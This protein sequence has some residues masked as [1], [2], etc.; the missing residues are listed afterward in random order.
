MNAAGFPIL[1]LLTWLPLVGGLFIMTVRGDEQT[2]ASNARW[3]ALWTSLI[4]FILSLLLWVRFDQSVPGFQFQE[5]QP[6]L[7]DYGVA[8][9]MGVDGISVLFVLLS[10]ALTPICILASWDSV[11]SRVREYMLA[12][13]VLETMMVGMFSAQDFVL[14]YVFFEGVLIPMFLIIGVW[15]GPRRVYASMKFFL[16]TLAGSVLLLLAL[17]AAW[18]QAGTTD[19]SVLMTT[20]FPARMQFWLF[21]AFFASFAV[22][23]PM[24]PL[25]TWLPDAHVEAPT[26]GSVILAGVLLKMGAYGFLRFSLPLLPDA[27]AHAAPWMYALG[28]VAVIY[29]SL[30]AL[31]QTD[32]K[33]LIAY[34][35][36]AHMGVVII[37]IFTFN[38]QGIEG[39]LVQMLSHGIVS[40]ALFLCVGVVYDRIHTRDIDRYGGLAERMPGYSLVFLFF[41]MASMGLPGT[42]GF[43]GEFLVLVGAFKVSLYLALLGSLGMILG[44]CYMLYLYRRIIFGTLTKLDLKGILDLSP[45]ETGR[46]R[47]AD[48]ADVLDGHLS[49]H[50]HRLLRRDRE[51]DGRASPGGTRRDPAGRDP[52]MNW[53]LALPEIVLA[54][55]AMAILIIGVLQKRDASLLCTML[56]IGALLIT[57]GL[58]LGNAYGSGYRGL[59]VSDG[60]GVF[61]K[62]LIL[63]G[64]G[65]SAILALDYNLREGIARFE[66]PVLIL[67]STVGM[68]IMSSTSSLMTL[69]LGL[70]LQSLALYVLCA[71][72][73]DDVRSAE[74]GLKFFILGALASGLLL[75]GIS[76]AYGFAGSMQFADLARTLTDPNASTT[77][78]VVGIVFIVAGLAFKLSAVPFH[79]WTPDV[80]EGAPTPVTAF[81]STAPKVA[82]I[83]LLLRVLEVPF[84]HLGHQWTQLIVLISI[85][86]MLL[87]SFAAIGQKNIK[88]LMAYSSIGHMGYALIGLAVGTAEGIQ[89]VLVY[90]VTYVFMSIGVFAILAAMRRRGRAL[91]QISDLAGLGRTDGLMAMIMAIL[92]FSMAGIP[93]F[94]G[95]LGKLYVFLPAIRSGYY[96]LAVI[97]VLTSVVGA[98]Y[99]LRVIKVMYFDDAAAPMDARPA[100][101]LFVAAVGGLATTFI[102]IFAAPIVSAAGV[103]ARVLFG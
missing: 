63:S 31:A 44:A 4:V 21:L 71:F 47:A 103:A 86:S 14:F 16:Y 32:M 22:K 95:F 93:P 18:F 56:A 39:A 82:A 27:S 3:A 42:S 51:R 12:F 101:N 85:A 20:D 10:T 37:G 46:V 58:V 61:L 59:F 1:S 24:W 69:Y 75:Y 9:R 87:G 40:A 17:L 80:Y 2:V 8:Y 96:T 5:S 26:A 34:S 60:F 70:E 38:L 102:V 91:D 79:M 19:I 30:V 99:Y 90:M 28:V 98:F 33:K 89:G 54:C 7:P 72:A 35:S 52:P 55:C 57:A 94:S 73:R 76:L 77:G 84:G 43:V 45:R 23:V 64:A 74:S 53:T 66:F 81:M 48:G 68:M 92:M 97:G 88:R 15:G 41:T 29:T 67:L 50:L 65:L 83:G 49:Q 25:H 36:V 62:L 11:K 78:L 100:S 13:L 6:W